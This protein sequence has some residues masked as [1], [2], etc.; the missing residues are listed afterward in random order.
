MRPRFIE[1]TGFEQSVGPFLLW[2]LLRETLK[3]NAKLFRGNTFIFFCERVYRHGQARC[4][5]GRPKGPEL[6]R[7]R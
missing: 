1:I 2:D 5:R 3:F 7:A 4:A 6:T